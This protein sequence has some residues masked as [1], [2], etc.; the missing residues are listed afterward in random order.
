M[1]GFYWAPYVPVAERRRQAARHIAKTK[2]GQSDFSP[3]APFGG[4][5]GKTFWGKAWCGN[6]ENYSDFSNRLP[7]GRTYLRNGSVIDLKIAMGKVQAQVLGSNL[8]KVEVSIDAVPDKRWKAICTDCASSID[9]LV[10]LLQGGLSK[11]VMERICKPG[12]GLF[13]KPKEIKF[14]CSCPDWAGMCKHVAAVLYGI[15]A[16]LDD[17]PELLFELRRV[18]AKALVAHA[19]GGL[20]RATKLPAGG[21]LLDSSNLADV[22]GIEMAVVSSLTKTAARPS[23][24][25]D[26]AEK[27]AE[28][29]VKARTSKRSLAKKSEDDRPA[30]LQDQ[31][32]PT[33]VRKSSKPSVGLTPKNTGSK[34]NAVPAAVGSGLK[35]APRGTK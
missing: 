6:L 17:Q 28:N 7:R 8:Y 32:E 24:R 20:K 30:P 3:V 29:P 12:S 2:K 4:T 22:F 18:D 35:R 34:A 5:I 19:G 25:K 9:S 13:P 26:I 16:R 31:V 33:K 23:K 27:V 15:G 1:K 21:R 11:A 14:S 10:E